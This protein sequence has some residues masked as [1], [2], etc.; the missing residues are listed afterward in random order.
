MRRFEALFIKV[1]GLDDADVGTCYGLWADTLVDAE[2]EALNLKM[3]VEAS[4]VKVLDREVVVRRLELG[5]H[6]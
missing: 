5:F 6:A 4:F 1:S 3:P 2:S